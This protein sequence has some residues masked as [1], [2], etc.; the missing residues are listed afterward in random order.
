[1]HAQAKLRADGWAADADNTALSSVS[2]LQAG[3]GVMLDYSKDA[4]KSITCIVGYGADEN[5]ADGR[6]EASYSLS[7]T[8]EITFF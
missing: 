7:C 4:G 6:L 8:R 1:M 3:N 5:T 2:D